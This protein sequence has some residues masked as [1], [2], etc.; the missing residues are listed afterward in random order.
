MGETFGE[1]SYLFV[2]VTVLEEGEE[3]C[4]LFG[5]QSFEEVEESFVDWLQK[6]FRIDWLK[7]TE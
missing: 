7:T 5:D 4:I 6:E 2:G 3:V 1:F